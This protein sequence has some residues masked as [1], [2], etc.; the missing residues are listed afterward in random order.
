MGLERLR[1]FFRFGNIS[2]LFPFRLVL[3]ECTGKFKRFDAHWRHPANWWFGFILLGHLYLL[4]LLLFVIQ[5]IIMGHAQSVPTTYLVALSLFSIGFFILITIPRL[6]LVRLRNLDL[7]LQIIQQ[8]DRIFDKISTKVPC[9]IQ[10]RIIIGIILGFILV[11][12]SN[13]IFCFKVN[14]E[15]LYFLKRIFQIP[16]VVFRYLKFIF[17][18]SASRHQLYFNVSFFSCCYN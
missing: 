8:I 18:W 2:G 7:S 9:T 4:I 15:L 3:D 14:N 5:H 17:L 1:L 10:R 11:I 12:K 16:S 13:T 6:F